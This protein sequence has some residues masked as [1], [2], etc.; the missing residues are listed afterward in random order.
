MRFSIKVAATCSIILLLILLSTDPQKLPSVTLILPFILLFIA[1]TSV[2]SFIMGVYG[3]SRRIRLKICFVG[4]STPVLLLVLQ[5]LGQLTMRDT[6]VIF[7]LFGVTY[8][9]MSRLGMQSAR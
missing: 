9:Y 4:A 3:M 1:L 6:L 7:A 8:F 5:S 2:M